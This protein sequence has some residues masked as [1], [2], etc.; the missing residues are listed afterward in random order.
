MPISDSVQVPLCFSSMTQPLSGCLIRML[1]VYREQR[2]T[3]ICI[4]VLIGLST[5]ITAVLRVSVSA[6]KFC[7]I[8]NIIM[9]I[10]SKRMRRHYTVV[11]RKPPIELAQASASPSPK[12]L[13][14][15][16]NQSP[17][18]LRISII[19]NM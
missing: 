19:M 14:R 7:S 11:G 9:I 5:L 3:G 16:Q 18:A 13:M 1:V 17:L 6:G 10:Q 12:H 4:H 15:P 8:L 2:M